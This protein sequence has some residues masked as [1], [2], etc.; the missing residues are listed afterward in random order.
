VSDVLVFFVADPVDDDL[1]REIRDRVTSLAGAHVWAGA[2]PGFFD[3]L[4]SNA[5]RRT[6][7]GY[8]RSPDVAGA[9][10][11]WDAAL[12]ASA[13]LGVTVELQWREAILGHVRAGEP[14]TGLREAVLATAAPASR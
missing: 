13:A 1:A 8:L 14:D 12:E 11:L 6:T 5:A 10:R 3:D 7:G 4:S 2:R 9:Q